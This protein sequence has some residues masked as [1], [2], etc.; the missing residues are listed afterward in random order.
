M[1]AKAYFF[2]QD[3]TCDSEHISFEQERGGLACPTHAQKHS[4]V[5]PCI[6][7]PA[8]LCPIIRVRQKRK[9]PPLVKGFVSKN[10]DELLIMDQLMFS[11]LNPKNSHQSFS[12]K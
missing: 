4:F 3:Y 12:V 11:H 2:F 10:E 9:C 6:S 7:F 5:F 1:E 8:Q